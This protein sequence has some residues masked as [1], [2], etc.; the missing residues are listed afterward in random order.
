MNAK[1][2]LYHIA[3][4]LLIALALCAALW[5]HSV[6]AGGVVEPPCDEAAL[7]AALSGGGSVT[8]NCGGPTFISLSSPLTITQATIVDGGGQITLHGGNSTRL[9]FVTAFVPLTLRNITLV[10]AHV[11]GSDGGAISSAGTLSLENSRILFSSTD[12]DHSGGA[13]FSTGPVFITNSVLAN[14]TGGSAGALFINFGN[15]KAQVTGSTFKE[16]QAANMSVGRGG[17]VWV[18]TLA[19]LSVVDSQFISNSAILGGGALFV[20]QGGTATLST[21]NVLSRT[22]FVGN[23]VTGSM[24]L[25]ILR[26]S[27]GGAIFSA[28]DLT[29]SSVNFDGNRAGWGGG[30]IFELSRTLSVRNSFFGNNRSGYSGGAIF[31]A[32]AALLI[33]GDTFSAN[34]AD[35]SGG[36]IN[37]WPSGSLDVSASVFDLNSAFADGGAISTIVQTTIREA[38]FSRNRSQASGGGAVGKNY[39]ATLTLE[40][41]TFVANTARQFA[42]AVSIFQ[43]AASLTNLTISANRTDTDGG[44]LYIGDAVD[45]NNVTLTGNTADSDNDGSGDGGGVYIYT[46]TVNVMNSI[47]AGNFDT[48]NNAG[49]GTLKPDCAGTLTSRGH[50]LVGIRDGCTGFTNGV[51]GDKVGSILTGAINPLLGPLANNGGTTQTHALLPGSPALNAGS[52]LAPGSGGFA[53]AATDQRGVRRPLGPRCDMGAYEAGAVLWLPLIRR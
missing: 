33:S 15:A 16:N 17:A 41:S 1:R 14:N 36:A 28:S 26:D 6:Q 50:N 9:F 13:I 37:A 53:C 22:S 52:P 24:G 42:G 45:I 30:A 48:P 29:I 32:A 25:D 39:S 5:S 2:L 46:G 44:G 34:I 4:A 35:Y 3:S 23:I 11:D 51:N 18:G 20:T 7:R 31:G 49:P 8:F 47:I 27:N 40:N 43:G 12:I 10:G 38:T 19:N 21:Q